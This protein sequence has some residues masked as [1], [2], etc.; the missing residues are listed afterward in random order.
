MARRL[1]EGLCVPLAVLL[2]EGRRLV[3]LAI[4]LAFGMSITMA[5]L[6][7]PRMSVH[8]GSCALAHNTR[9]SRQTAKT[10]RGRRTHIWVKVWHG[11]LAWIRRESIGGRNRSLKAC[12][13]ERR[14]PHERGRTLAE[15]IGPAVVSAKAI[16]GLLGTFIVKIK[17]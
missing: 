11:R 13:H 16:I 5:S 3:P 12:A 4:L 2:V 1:G 17:A 8:G 10:G 7:V 14:G 9:T 15:I 6:L